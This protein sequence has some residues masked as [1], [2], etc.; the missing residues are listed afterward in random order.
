[1]IWKQSVPVSYRVSH[2]R[3]PIANIKDLIVS[4]LTKIFEVDI[5]VYF[6]FIIIFGNPVYHLSFLLQ[7]TEY[8]KRAGISPKLPDAPLD[9]TEDFD[10]RFNMAAAK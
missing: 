7:V 8:F 9:L 3:R 1:M 4:Y 2:K 5:F 10:A 6:L